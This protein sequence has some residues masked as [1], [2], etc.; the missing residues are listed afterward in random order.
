MHSQTKILLTILAFAF[1]LSVITAAKCGPYVVDGLTLG[2]KIPFS[3]AKYKLY[4][5]DPSTD[6]DGLTWCQREEPK[7]TSA[8]KGL[9]SSTIMH[10]EDGTALYLMANLAPVSISRSTAQKEIEELSKEV[11]EN[12]AKVEWARP[13][14]PD[15]VIAVWGK[16]ELNALTRSEV[17]KIANG[18][19]LA[20]RGILVDTLGDLERSAKR[21]LPVYRIVGGAGYLYAASFDASGRGHRHYV[22]IDLSLNAIPKF[23]SAL[24]KILQE[25][26][27]RPSND[28]RLWPGVHEVTRNLALDTSPKI[29]NENLDR[30]FAQYTSKKLHSHVW[31]ILPLSTLGVLGLSQYAHR[32]ELIYGPES[33]YSDVRLTIQRFLAQ[34]PTAPFSEF[35]HYTIG[36]FEKA[37]RA[38]PNSVVSSVLNYAAGY[39]FLELI[40][41]DAKRTVRVRASD[42]RPVNDTLVA[43]NQR[44]ELYGSQ[45]LGDLVPKFATRAAAAKPYFE[46]VLRDESSPLRDDAAY[47][48]GWLAFHQGK[49]KEAFDY[50][51]V[52]AEASR[53]DSEDTKKNGPDGPKVAN[54]SEGKANGT[55]QVADGSN[56][57]SESHANDDY[58]EA[59]TR[60]LARVLV[61]LPLNEQLSLIESNTVLA[62]DRALWWYVTTRGAYRSLNHKLTMELG[63]KA[64]QALNVPLDRLPVTTNSE[65]INEALSQIDIKGLDAENVSEIIY[66]MEAS[67]E[68][69]EYTD[70]LK[71]VSADAPD[72]VA[73]KV[74]AMILKYSL[75]ID[76]AEKAAQHKDLRQAVQLIEMTLGSVPKSGQHAKLREWLHYRRVRNLAQFNPKAVAAAV[77]AMEQEF[78][79]SELMDDALAEQIYAE[80]ARMEDADAARRT[81]EKLVSQ[82]PKGNAVDNA[83]NWMAVSYH[84]VGMLEQAQKMNRAIVR[85][86]PTTRHADNARKR[87]AEPPQGG[88]CSLSILS[89]DEGEA[90]RRLHP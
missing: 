65:R 63:K 86:F 72:A 64:L 12:P 58:S 30:V 60:Q 85:L 35:L 61:R 2:Q 75:L 10:A 74:R 54:A 62:A 70:Y 38:N 78:R 31:S 40:L 26:Q 55:T 5:C 43:L 24:R 71:R 81:F 82:F 22:A 46:T 25:D 34:N 32:K 36:E 90:P 41:Q 67:R 76:D 28:Y 59:A 84:C 11:N 51:I 89:F 79:K 17:E 56:G 49:F 20:R 48:L 19:P 69:V 15:S 21:K 80:G 52:A 33:E 29:A 18:E 42:Y 68:I 27:A 77:A 6:F 45:L 4:K 50:T 83:Y 1:E 53:D 39:Q 73:K 88:D 7:V 14:M 37:V 13:G 57:N 23:E 87:L 9:F 3:G 47:M 44:P 66:L 16:I 8:G